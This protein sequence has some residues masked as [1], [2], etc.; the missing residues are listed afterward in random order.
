MNQTRVGAR[1]T[2]VVLVDG[3]CRWVTIV[4]AD[5]GGGGGLVAP[6]PTICRERVAS[7]QEQ[8][9]GDGA[10]ASLGLVISALVG[11]VAACVIAG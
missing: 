1:A 4:I 10:H 8:G 6:F 11:G 5:F 9:N 3:L 2:S 7:W